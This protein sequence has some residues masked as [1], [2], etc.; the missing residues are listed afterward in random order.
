MNSFKDRQ[1]AFENKYAHDQDMLFK[2]EARA[3]KLFGLW[4]GEQLGLGPDDAK[5]YA[6]EMV[7]ENLIEPGYDDIKRKAVADFAAKGVDVSEHIIDSMIEKSMLE[8]QA[9]IETEVPKAS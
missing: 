7:G 8:A 4:A 3:S 6:A 9:Q 1:T 5:T 2:I